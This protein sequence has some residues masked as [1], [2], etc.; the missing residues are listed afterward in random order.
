MLPSLTGSCQDFYNNSIALHRCSLK[1][2]LTIF[3]RFPAPHEHES[4]RCLG[5]AQGCTTCEPAS[6]SFPSV[7]SSMFSRLVSLRCAEKWC[8]QLQFMSAPYQVLDPLVDFPKN[9]T[10]SLV[11]MQINQGKET[12]RT[13]A[14]AAHISPSPPETDFCNPADSSPSAYSCPYLRSKTR[15]SCPTYTSVYSR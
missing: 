12:I 13:S 6:A 1:S 8:Q 5:E 2:T 3:S 7:L 11:K 14:P 15:A 9:P 4:F 10:T